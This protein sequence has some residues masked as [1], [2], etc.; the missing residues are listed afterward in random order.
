MKRLISIIPIVLMV[1]VGC[2]STDGDS[3][4]FPE[5]S[6]SDKLFRLESNGVLGCFKDYSPV[7]LPDPKTPEEMAEILGIEDERLELEDRREIAKDGRDKIVFWLPFIF[8]SIA[9]TFFLKSYGLQFV[10]VGGFAVSLSF[11]ISGVIEVKMAEKWA[12][13]TWTICGLG[14]GGVVLF[15]LGA[16]ML[17]DKG[18]GSPGILGKWLDEKTSKWKKKNGSK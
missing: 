12:V 15:A 5:A 18:L 10:G 3:S 11:F 14:L 4:R 13:S 1:L 2:S 8:L 6:P 16:F 7:R 17:K 9:A